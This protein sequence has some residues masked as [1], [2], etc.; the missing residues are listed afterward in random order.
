MMVVGS[1]FALGSYMGR[2]LEVEH[3]SF[4][5]SGVKV[6]GLVLPTGVFKQ[7][8]VLSWESLGFS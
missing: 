3:L 2:V 1:Y 6:C 8:G 5:V 7:N 4:G